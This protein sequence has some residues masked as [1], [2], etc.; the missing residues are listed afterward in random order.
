MANLADLLPPERVAWLEV[1]T[2][3]E[4]LRTL[5]ELVTRSQAVKD[6]AALRNAMFSR[7]VIMSTGVGYGVALP[8][9]KIPAVDSFVLALGISHD[10]IPYNGILD[11]DPVR[12]IVMIAGPDRSQD[13]YLKL[14]STLMK[15]IK[16]EKGKILSSSSAEEV[17]RL[18]RSYV[19]ELP[20]I[21][22]PA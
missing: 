6:P 21:P 15:F 9:A 1:G 10:G 5:L 12:L 3:D 22:S 19:L 2:K 16:S 18:A 14:L 17:S 4:A 8:H 11:D 7:E 20:A 13:G